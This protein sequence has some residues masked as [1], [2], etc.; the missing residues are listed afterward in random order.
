ML[1]LGRKTGESIVFPDLG[2]TVQI[3]DNDH[4]R[5]SVGVEA[6]RSVVVLRS[7]LLDDVP[8]DT[9]RRQQPGNDAPPC[10]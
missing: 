5:V 1:V 3:L 8:P 7:E 10:G 4:G 2:I 9:G 6:P